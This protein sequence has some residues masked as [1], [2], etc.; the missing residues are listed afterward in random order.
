[1]AGREYSVDGMSDAQREVLFNNAIGGSNPL[2][3]ILELE[4]LALDEGYDNVHEYIAFLRN[5]TFN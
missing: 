5:S 4:Q 2:D 3:L 1:M